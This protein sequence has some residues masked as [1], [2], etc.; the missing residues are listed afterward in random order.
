MTMDPVD[1][2]AKVVAEIAGSEESLS[3]FVFHI[4]DSE[5]ST[6]SETKLF[7][8]VNS[9]GWPVLFETREKFKFL[10]TSN[11]S[12]AK[13]A[14]F[15]LMH[16]MMDMSIKIDNAN[17]RSIYPTPCPSTAALAKKCLIYLYHVHFLNEPKVPSSE[18][19]DEEY[20]EVSIFTRTGR[21]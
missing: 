5:H 4:S 17:T 14:L 19:K 11:P 7:E 8:I 6:I 13:N 10:L 3:K 2:V 21:N 16:M 15:P 9:F 18:L 1:H 12:A 20:P